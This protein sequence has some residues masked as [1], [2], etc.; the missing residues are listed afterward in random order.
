MRQITQHF[1]LVISLL[2]APVVLIN[3]VVAQETLR[4]GISPD[5]PPLV[6]KQEGQ[7]TGIEVAAGETI[8]LQ[9]NRKAEFV[10]LP[11]NQLIP[12]LQAGKIDIVMSGM[13]ATPERS[14]LVDFSDTYLNAGQMAI[15]RYADAGRL[16]YK[17]TLFRPGARVAVIKK[18]TGED[19]ANSTLRNAEISHCDSIRE[20]LAKLKSGSVDFVIHGAA[21]SWSLSTDLSHQ[22]FM[23]L[24]TELTDE[25]LAWAV[26]KN[27]GRLLQ[28]VNQQLAIMKKNGMLRAIINKWIPVTVEVQTATPTPTSAADSEASQVQSSSIN[29]GTR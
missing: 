28:A 6:F 13:S 1:L 18:T 21:T 12:A 23:S 26:N 15:I 10:E 8:A 29:R 7:L 25:K 16:G 17:G 9:L 4:I 22:E 27:N 3:T 20:A 11:F 5:Y 19:F 24:N 2:F 14:R